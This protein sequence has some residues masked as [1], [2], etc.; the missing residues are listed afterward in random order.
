MIIVIA[1]VEIQESSREA[2]LDEFRKV[3]PDVLQED[4]CLQ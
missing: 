1:T 3:V 4:G 2:F